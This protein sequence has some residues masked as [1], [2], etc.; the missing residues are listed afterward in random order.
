M[1]ILVIEDSRLLEAGIRRALTKAGHEVILTTDGQ[2]GL[3]TARR[4][5]PD[6]VLLDMMLPG[7]SGTGVLEAL[8]SHPATADVPVVVL[9][10][11]SRKNEEKLL[12]AGAARYF[13]KSDLLLHDNFASVVDAIAL[14]GA[15][16]KESLPRD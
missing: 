8:K 2:E 4:I 3:D 14:F 16:L 7:L 15:S 11:L 1:K 13:E 10:G 6:L 12:R 5:R 9:T